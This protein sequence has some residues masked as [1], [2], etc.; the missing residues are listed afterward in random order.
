MPEG[1]ITADKDVP[2][3]ESPHVTRLRNSRGGPYYLTPD[4]AEPLPSGMWADLDPDAVTAESSRIGGLLDSGRWQLGDLDP[5]LR[6][7][8]LGDGAVGRKLIEILGG[9]PE[10]RA[11][12]Q[13]TAEDP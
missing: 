5:D 2:T 1:Q 9:E 4:S 3:F 11:D 10:Q 13:A 6:S 8:L 12:E 7:F